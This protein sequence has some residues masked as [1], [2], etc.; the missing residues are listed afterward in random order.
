VD[1]VI[2]VLNGQD[3]NCVVLGGDYDLLGHFPGR[4]ASEHGKV[5][6]EVC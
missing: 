2:A 5:R 4:T 3:K 1:K 6:Q